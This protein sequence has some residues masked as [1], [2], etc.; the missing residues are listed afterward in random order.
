MDLVL[1]LEATKD[2]VC[3][4]LEVFELIDNLWI[5][6]ALFAN[7]VKL[8]IQTE[9]LQTRQ[10]LGPFLLRWRLIDE[11]VDQTESG[12]AGHAPVLF[13]H[14]QRVDQLIERCFVALRGLVDGSLCDQIESVR[15]LWQLLDDLDEHR[16]RSV[17]QSWVVLVVHELVQSRE[18]VKLALDVLS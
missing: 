9:I 8:V 11:Q 16:R 10:K 13:T 17:A 5:A 2:L 3:V 6:I 4:D 12:L 15:A 7:F 14:G 1:K 18:E